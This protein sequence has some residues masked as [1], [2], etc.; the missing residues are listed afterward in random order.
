MPFCRIYTNVKKQ[1]IPENFCEKLVKAVSDSLGK[2]LNYVTICVI[3]DCLMSTNGTNEPSALV[4]LTSIENMGEME[5]SN[6]AAAINTCIS[7]QLKVP[8]DRIV[9]QF[10]EVKPF[11]V[12][13]GDKTANKIA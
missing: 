6:H 10:F 2:P 1:D 8:M 13:V 4:T 9:I 5:N 3:P 12:G 7:E 11:E